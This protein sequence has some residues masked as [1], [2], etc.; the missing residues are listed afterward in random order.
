[1]GGQVAAGAEAGARAEV[2]AEVG[3]ARAVSCKL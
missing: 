1:V 2:G 3:G